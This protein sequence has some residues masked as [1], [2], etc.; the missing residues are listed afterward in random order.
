MAGSVFTTVCQEVNIKQ[1]VNHVH[2]PESM[3][4]LR[5][6]RSFNVRHGILHVLRSRG[7]VY[8]RV[9]HTRHGTFVEQGIRR[10]FSSS[11]PM[12]TVPVNVT[13]LL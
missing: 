11:A 10:Q 9:T 4:R 8:V 2:N 1:Q 5:H 3:P 6:H 12:K 13:K 7:V